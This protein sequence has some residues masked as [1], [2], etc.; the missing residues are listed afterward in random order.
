MSRNSALEETVGAL[1]PFHHKRIA[2]KLFESGKR[3]RKLLFDTRCADDHPSLAT[4]LQSV[5]RKLHRR[6]FAGKKDEIDT[7]LG[8]HHPK[9]LQNTPIKPGEKKTA[10][11]EETW[12]PKDTGE[13]DDIRKDL[14]REW[15]IRLR[16]KPIVYH[17]D[18]D[19]W[20]MQGQEYI[21]RL[22]ESPCRNI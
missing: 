11:S 2:T 14:R 22:E 12:S 15:W 8:I 17:E 21:D 9:I 3:M 18:Q 13:L 4:S 7:I 6:C 10:R 5:R 20:E 19:Q 1:F 16:Q